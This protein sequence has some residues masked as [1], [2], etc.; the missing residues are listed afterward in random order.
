M[1][2]PL[3]IAFQHYEPSE[4]VRAELDKQARRL[5]KFSGRITSGHVVVAGPQMRRQHGDLFK[6]DIRL[7]MPGHNDVIVSKAHGDVPEHEH[8]LV[9][10]RDAF[11]AAIRQ[12]EDVSRDLRGAVKQHE[13]EAHGRVARFLAGED[14]GFIETPDGR[15]IYFHR[16]AVLDGGFDRMTIGDEVRFVEE[17]GEKGAQ[18]STVRLIGKHHI[19]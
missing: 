16:N 5:E 3:N 14:C 2:V 1:Q 12:V 4:A 10:I 15:Q 19:A 6:V 18:A 11:D 17:R 9:A 7:A 13:P 8:A